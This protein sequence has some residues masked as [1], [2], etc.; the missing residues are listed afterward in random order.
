[1]R[2]LKV[3]A[4]RFHTPLPSDGLSRRS[5]DTPVMTRVTLPSLRQLLVSRVS[6]Y[7]ED[8]LVESIPLRSAS[9]EPFF[10]SAHFYYL[11]PFA[12]VRNLT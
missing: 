7:L 2:S 6:P 12:A 10:Q 11:T 3:P 5:L 1:M 9:S 8:L 4:I